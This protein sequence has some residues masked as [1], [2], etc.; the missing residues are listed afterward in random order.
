VTTDRRV[1]GLSVA[2]VILAGVLASAFVFAP[3]ACEGGLDLYFWSGVAGLVMLVSL[4][5]VVHLGGSI[6]G[7]IGWAFGFF[8]L[9]VGVWLGGLVAANVQILCRLF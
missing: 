8:L 5:F 1:V 2:G 3:R 9:G 6:L 7:S 4:P